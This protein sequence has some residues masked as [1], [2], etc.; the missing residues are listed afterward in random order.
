M[1]RPS[2]S[3]TAAAADRGRE[4]GVR[5]DDDELQVG[6]GASST[7]CEHRPEEPCDRGPVVRHHVH[8][9]LATRRPLTP[10]PT[11]ATSAVHPVPPDT[12]APYIAPV[13]RCAPV[14]IATTLVKYSP[15]GSGLQ[16]RKRDVAL[17]RPPTS[18]DLRESATIGVR[19]APR[20]LRA[21]GRP[22]IDLGAGEPD[23]PTPAL[24]M[25]AARS[26][27][28][29]RRDAIHAGRR[30]SPAARRSSPNGRTRCRQL[31][32]IERRRRRRQRRDEAG[33]LQRLLF[34]LRQSA[35]K[36]SFR[37]PDGRATT[38]WSSL[39]RADTDRRPRVA[40]NGRLK[41]TPEDLRAAATPR[42]RGL[43]PQ[44]AHAIRP[45]L[46]IRA[47]SSTAIVEL[48]RRAGVVDPQRRD[49]SRDLIRRP[50]RPSLFSVGR[51]TWIASIVVDGVAKSFA[52]TGWRIG[53]A[54]APRLEAAR[55]M[56]ALQ[57]HTT[58]NAG[59]V[60]QHAALAALSEGAR[61]VRRSTRWSTSSASVARRRSPCLARRRCPGNRPAGAFYL[62]IHAGDATPEDPAPGNVVR[63]AAARGSRRS[64][65]YRARH[66]GSPEWIRV[67]YAA[68][69]DQVLEGVRRIIERRIS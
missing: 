9:V 14:N 46:C 10:P 51:R 33:A 31:N 18:L 67:S 59:T 16:Y 56:T 12:P 32:G 20:R 62:Y 63:A 5:R 50:R 23:F 7:R 64:R 68:P 6:R 28:R 40:A 36:C 4:L 26:C 30:D 54:I 29:R 27:A 15:R 45:A 3:L 22:V 60:S 2:E 69:R 57:S 48:R 42:T 58:S 66:F 55:A 13:A 49:L 44:L 34:S 41:V 21:A 17:C 39:A 8:G 1:P 38:R 11:A 61:R 19:R 43:D 25:D 52:M 53:W 47:R 24:V 35:M 65:S 37:R